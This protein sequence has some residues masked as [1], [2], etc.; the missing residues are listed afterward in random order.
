MRYHIIYF[1]LHHVKLM[2]RD[3]S[4]QE[5]GLFSSFECRRYDDVGTYWKL[6]STTHLPHVDVGWSARYRPVRGKKCAWHIA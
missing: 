4:E 5:V 2:L 3:Y 1:Y 6:M